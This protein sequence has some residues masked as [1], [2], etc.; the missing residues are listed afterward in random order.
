[1]KKIFHPDLKQSNFES[2]N[3]AYKALQVL[4]VVSNP[5]YVKAFRKQIK[6]RIF[7]ADSNRIVYIQIF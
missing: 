1:M 7:E 2:N 6:D 4:A 3:P 5:I